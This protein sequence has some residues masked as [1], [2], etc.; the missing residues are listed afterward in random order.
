M[1]WTH[2]IQP[3]G[4]PLNKWD[5]SELERFMLDSSIHIDRPP[6]KLENSDTK[7]EYI[8]QPP[9]EI[10]EPKE[11]SLY[12]KCKKRLLYVEKCQDP[13]FWSLYIYH[14]GMKE[15]L[16]VGK[17]N[18]N[19][20]MKVKK[21]VVDHLLKTGSKAMTSR[22]NTKFTKVGCGKM[23][24]D[25]L[26]KPK[27]TMDLL[28]PFCLF[29]KCNIYVVD[30]KKKIYL[31]YAFQDATDIDQ[32]IIYRNPEKKYPEY[33]VDVQ[34]QLYPKAYIESQFICLYSYVK[35]LK[36]VS[37]FKANELEYLAKELGIDLSEK[38]K[39]A[40]LYHILSQHCAWDL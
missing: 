22:L 39:K 8:D 7:E 28:Y 31:N 37:N 27:T 34:E 21:E 33:F 11:E 19:E 1:Y 24:E 29:F 25:I 18:G 17:Y 20:E 36:A 26:T 12:E 10:I 4:S 15:Y 35:P 6:A 9:S 32:L 5:L 23:A 14:Y 3:N 40:E 30:L 16:R 38:K 13:L 2:W